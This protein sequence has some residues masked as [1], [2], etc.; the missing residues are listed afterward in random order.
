MNEPKVKARL[1]KDV[2]SKIKTCKLDKIRKIIINI[3][4][5]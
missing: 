4:N 3:Y 2:Y 5:W 1:F